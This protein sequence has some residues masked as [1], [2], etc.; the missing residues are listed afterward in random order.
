MGPDDDN[1]DVPRVRMRLHAVFI[2]VKDR[3]RWCATDDPL[4][5]VKESPHRTRRDAVPALDERVVAA[6]DR[7]VVCRERRKLV[8]PV[9]RVA[10]QRRV[11]SDAARSHSTSFGTHGYSF[12]TRRSARAFVKSPHLSPWLSARRMRLW[13]AT[14]MHVVL[15]NR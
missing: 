2:D 7:P 13:S 15:T 3:G 5:C 8:V 11:V 6:R 9:A 1:V 12:A 4:L 14:S 10:D